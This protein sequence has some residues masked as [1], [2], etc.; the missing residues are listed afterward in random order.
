ML[1]GMVMGLL[2]ATQ[3]AQP[4]ADTRA[5]YQAYQDG[6]RQVQQRNWQAAIASLNTAKRTGP[7]PGR[8]IPFY[9]DVY[10]DFLPDYY[11]GLAYINTQQY[12]E[13]ASAFDAVRQTGLITA[14]DKEYAEF[15]KQSASAAAQVAN[16]ATVAQ[17][18]PAQGPPAQGPPAAQP[19]PAPPVTQ[20]ANADVGNANAPST[21]APPPVATAAPNPAPTNVPQTGAAAARPPAT[22]ATARPTPPRPGTSPNQPYQAPVDLK[23][24][25]AAMTAFFEGDYLRAANMLS[26]LTVNGGTPRAAFYLACSRAALVLTGG[27]DAATL[28]DARTRFA[29][30]NAAAFAADERYISPRVLALLRNE[31]R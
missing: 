13:A 2:I 22:T 7:K 20:T 31:A 11:L 23:S 27:A 6:V 17:G 8:R 25:S 15:T 18:P 24:E 19:V 29:G 4:R 5:W 3:S 14:K 30:I 1:L 21:A 28:A 10:D 12:K 26:G 9:G 16:T